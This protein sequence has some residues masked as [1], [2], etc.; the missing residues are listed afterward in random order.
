MCCW[1]L[2]G[3]YPFPIYDETVCERPA[4]IDTYRIPRAV[5]SL[6]YQDVLPSKGQCLA[7]CHA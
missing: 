6:V 5:F 2:R 3:D 1:G 4:N 7:Q